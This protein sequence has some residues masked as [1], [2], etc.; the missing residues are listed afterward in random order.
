MAAKFVKT[1][2]RSNM[3]TPGKTIALAVLALV[4]A[5]ANVSFA[6]NAPSTPVLNQ[7]VPRGAQRGA[8]T[9]FTFAGA[10]LFDAKEVFFYDEGFE[11]KKIE[12]VDAN[13]VKVTV[14][15]SADCRIGEHV[16][17]LR[18]TGGVSDYR[19]FFVGVLPEVDEVEPNS[20]FDSPQKIQPGTTVNGVIKNEDLDWFQVQ[21]KAGQRLS[22]EIEAIRLGFM[23][24]P[25]I[26]I[27][28][29][30]G[31]ELAKCDD[32][33]LLKQDAFLSIEAPADGTYTIMVRETSYGGNDNCRYRLHVGDFPRPALVYPAGG[34]FGE[35]RELTFLGG[36]AG[37]MKQ[38]VTL[39]EKVGFRGGLFCKD[40]VGVSPSPL[41]FLLSDL[42]SVEEVEPNNGFLQKEA[43]SPPIAIDGRLMK[44]D[45]TDWHRFTAMKGQTWIIDCQARRIGSPLDPVINVYFA[46]SKKHIA[47]NDDFGNKPDAQMRFQVPEDGDYFVRVKD[48]RDRT[49][50]DF[51]YRLQIEAPKPSLTVNI[52][53]N[54]R[55][56]Q[57]RQ[58]IAIPKGN[59][60][61]LL[62]DAA[63]QNF[64]GQI[65]LIADSLP[66]GVTM[67]CKPMAANMNFMPV[68][69]TAT[70]DAT[71]DGG[72]F[73]FKA[74]L[75]DKPE[76]NG[77]YRLRADLVLGVPNNTLYYPCFVDKAAVAVLDPVPF[78]LEMVA[79]QAPLLRD[80]QATVK[81]KIHRDEGFDK[82]V[83][84][85]FPFR[86]PGVGTNYQ[87]KVKKD[88]N[89]FDYP[90]NANGNAQ[91]GKWPIYVIGW[92]DVKGQAWISTQLSELEIAEPRVKMQMAMTSVTQGESAEMKCTLEQLVGF[93]GEATAELLG[94]PPN[95]K[96]NSPLKFNAQTKELT[97][98]FETTAKSPPGKHGPFVRV[99]IPHNAA[100]MVATAG[101]G[102]LRINKPRPPKKKQVAKK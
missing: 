39:P 19:N 67:E 17:Q 65:K 7:I 86:P 94:V 47:G 59:R 35:T 60:F 18:T 37:P 1:C 71:I 85:Q 46:K 93:E 74:E 4:A 43:F 90:L 91:I 42:N 54:D 38:T 69:F 2:W 73:D 83:W 97:F 101:R 45:A 26:E 20:E 95:V 84:L 28:D 66:A 12:Q 64:G 22:V 57:R 29:A 33:P 88:K 70:E 25:Y 99:T 81:I 8:E 96:T 49:G 78:K 6:N 92:S 40:E 23:F 89:E 30:D 9:T 3:H 14:A 5:L 76:V 48:H 53:R 79:P 55:Y 32:C 58:Q 62:M 41:P 31:N 82:D 87:V 21:A 11:V 24:D 15:I 77:G 75:V 27:R 100:T 98:K 68:V 13:N 36:P 61:G 56:S 102:Q 52:R 44:D 72:L 34:K 63:K 16:A 51:I 80:G 10:R 50:D